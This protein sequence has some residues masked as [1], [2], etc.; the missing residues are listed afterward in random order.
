VTIVNAYLFT[1]G[2][3]IAFD[4]D[5]K[6]VPEYQGRGRVVIPKLRRDFPGLIIEGVDWAHRLSEQA[7]AVARNSEFFRHGLG[8]AMGGFNEPYMLRQFTEYKAERK[9][10]PVALINPRD[11][12]RGCPQCGVIDK[13]NRNTQDRFSCVHCGHEAAADFVGAQ[14]IR[15]KGFR[16]LG[17]ALAI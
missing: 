7:G 9:G 17:A 16:A 8:R 15:S 6:Q 14:N 3:V 1:N 13:A 11:T 5:A 4:A 10:I 2:V 12:S